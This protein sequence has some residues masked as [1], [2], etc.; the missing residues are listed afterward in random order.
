MLVALTVNQRQQTVTQAQIRRKKALL[1]EDIIL[2][3]NEKLFSD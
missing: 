2:R 3:K 1:V